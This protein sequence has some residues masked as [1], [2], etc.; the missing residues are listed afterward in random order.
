MIF[1]KRPSFMGAHQD[2]Q[3]NHGFNQT[4][5]HGFNKTHSVKGEADQLPT[6]PNERTISIDEVFS[7]D[8]FMSIDKK[9]DLSQKYCDFTPE[10]AA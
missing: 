10:N 8:D 1:G 3:R 5:N 2:Q 7:Q 4:H 6:Q 9:E